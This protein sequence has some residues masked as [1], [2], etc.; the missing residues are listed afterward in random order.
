M[1]RG[2]S[3]DAGVDAAAHGFLG[4]VA[5]GQEE[6]VEDSQL[7]QLAGQVQVG[8]RDEEFPGLRRWY[9]SSASCYRTLMKVGRASPWPAAVKQ[10]T[11]SVAIVDSLKWWHRW[12]MQSCMTLVSAIV[13][14]T[15]P[16]PPG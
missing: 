1:G 13:I 15:A 3:G 10:P 7:A 14:R 9:L 6:E 8:F 12:R 5:S 11:V 2:D 4:Q 16:P